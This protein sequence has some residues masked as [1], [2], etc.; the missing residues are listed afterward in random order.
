[1]K[2]C[3]ANLLGAV[4]AL[5]LLTGLTACNRQPE[6]PPAADGAFLQTLVDRDLARIP[7]GGNLVNCQ[8]TNTHVA[9][10]YA[11]I[12]VSCD[13]GERLEYAYYASERQV[14]SGHVFYSGAG[15]P[16]ATEEQIM[17]AV[18]A[19]QMEAWMLVDKRDHFRFKPQGQ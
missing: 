2:S 13:K 15:A 17:I 5:L 4:V 8:R 14:Y 9:G 7:T 3:Y 12:E 18:G 11:L 1:M 6:D 19:P 16:L 10:R